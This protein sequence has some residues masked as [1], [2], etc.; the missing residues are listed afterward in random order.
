[1]INKR[2]LREFAQLFA[3]MTRARA[4]ELQRDGLSLKCHSPPQMGVQI[5]WYF[6]RMKNKNM[7][8]EKSVASARNL[9]KT[10]EYRKSQGVDSVV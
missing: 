6:W 1:M 3:T 5:L 7:T 10:M 9:I 2:Q 4:R 8:G